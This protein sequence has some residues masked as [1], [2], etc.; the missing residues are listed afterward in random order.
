M[1]GAPYDRLQDVADVPAADSIWALQDYRWLWATNV[2][3]FCGK[4]LMKMASLQW[5][6]EH[7]RSNM[8]LGGLGVIGLVTQLPSI[9]FGGV[10]ADEM[11]RR[12]LVSYMQVVAAGTCAAVSALDSTGLLAPWHIYL[13]IG[14]LNISSRLE[15]SARNALTPLIV[16]AK[17][18]QGAISTNV[19]TDNAGELLAPALFFWN[20]PGALALSS[21]CVFDICIHSGCN[22]TTSNSD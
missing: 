22:A 8:V 5:L 12:K 20:H 10:L 16:P 2:A 7:T 17:L 3:V 6:Y 11:D 18:L 4:I 14:L 9:L 15:A 1:K 13:A 19:V 21:L